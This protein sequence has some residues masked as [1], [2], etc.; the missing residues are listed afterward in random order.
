M[1]YGRNTGSND[2]NNKVMS[3]KIIVQKQLYNTGGLMLLKINLYPLLTIS[4]SRKCKN[5]T[6]ISLETCYKSPLATENLCHFPV[7]SIQNGYLICRN[8]ILN[9]TIPNS[10]FQLKF[11]LNSLLHAS[12]VKFSAS[13]ENFHLDSSLSE[14]A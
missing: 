7:D 6:I 5:E 13:R 11:Q 10:N 12:M 8:F 2:M 14:Q 3:F 1:Q 4:E 9:D